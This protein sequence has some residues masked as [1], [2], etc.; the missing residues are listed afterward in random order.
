MKINKL[1][2]ILF[3]GITFLAGCTKDFVEINTN[4][5]ASSVASPQSLL[6]PVL[7]STINNNLDRNFRINN[8]LMQVT[9]TTSDARE[10]HRYEIK[11]SESEY[12]WRVW[13]SSLTDIRDIYTNAEATRQ[14]GYQTFQGIS[15]ILETWVT[16]LLTDA[17]GDVPYSNAIEGR[18]GNTTPYFDK[19]QDIYTDLFKKLDSANALLSVKVNLPAD[20]SNTEPV[21]GGDA[22]KWQKFGNSLFLRLLMRVA[23]KPESNAIEKIKA[24]VS[25][26]LLYP[27]IRD[28]SESAILY[29]T[30]KLP[31]VTRFYNARDFDFNG[32]KGYSE[33]FIN[34]LM[35]LQDPRLS[36]WATEASLGVYGGMQSGYPK[37]AV[38]EPQS[39]LQLS[40]K[41]EPLLGNIMNYAE[42]QFILAEA[43]L[44]G[45]I[46]GDA[47]AYYK[48]GVIANMEMWGCQVP[49]NYFTKPAASFSGT[50]RELMNKLFLQKYFSLMFTDFQ[51]WYEYRRTGLPELYIGPGLLNG[52]KMPVRFNYPLIVQS[53]NKSNYDKAV[54]GMGGDSVNEKMW[55]QP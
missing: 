4:P 38:P 39:R 30:N 27:I 11:P 17:F 19:Q 16:S 1:L 5:N 48:K 35:E 53:L 22:A 6:A 50:E 8:E 10:F 54:A 3:A 29:F 45:Y 43:V 2:F 26:P 51:Q 25:N 42:L 12:M 15:L 40:L 36:R 34:N 21:Y 32:D 28:S 20:I 49:E 46:N 52:G 33:F 14:T 18:K 37:G 9:V 55:W 23:H 13:Y 24:I 31:Y 7:V 44:R 41:T 47:E